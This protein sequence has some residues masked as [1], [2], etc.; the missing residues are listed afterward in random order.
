[1][2]NSKAENEKRHF[3]R[4]PFISK[5][6]IS[7]NDR[8]VEC[9][10]LDLSLKGLLIEPPENFTISDNTLYTIVLTLSEEAMV[11]MQAKLVHTN[12]QYYGL[13][14]LDIDLD[15]LT[16][17]RRI[18]ELNSNDPDEIHRE[19]ADLVSENTR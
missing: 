12:S 5:V 19:L 8:S 16:T 4:V 13:E 11:S 10:L 6:T 17:L 1:M 7:S 15:S 2:T 18:L 14:W 3:C 9:G